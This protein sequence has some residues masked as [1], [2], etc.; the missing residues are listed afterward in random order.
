M[1]PALL[2]LGQEV[3][4][5]PTLRVTATTTEEEARAAMRVLGPFN[6]CVVG[7]VRFSGQT[8]W[9]RHAE[10]EL[11][12]VLDGEVDVTVLTDDGPVDT[13]VPTGCVFIVPRAHWHRQLPRP[14]VTLLFVTGQ[15]DVSAG[16]DPRRDVDGLGRRGG[17]W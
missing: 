13:T 5:D 11:L 15:T 7:L 2:R 8:P 12:H 17:A 14:T 3:L 4:G 10:D 6:Q 9:E 16:D 1:N